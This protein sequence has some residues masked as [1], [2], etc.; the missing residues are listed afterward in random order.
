MCG[1]T[2]SCYKQISTDHRVEKS[3][4]SKLAKEIFKKFQVDF[5]YVWYVRVCMC[6]R[7]R[8]KKKK[9]KKRR[10]SYER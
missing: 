6:G 1:F 7:E 10:K 9:K 5:G 3:I 8:E 4:S 2:C